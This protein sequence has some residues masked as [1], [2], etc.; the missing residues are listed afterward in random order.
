[1]A[2]RPFHRRLRKPSDQVLALLLRGADVAEQGDEQQHQHA[3]G[4]RGPDEDV[5]GKQGDV[6]ERASGSGSAGLRPLSLPS[7]LS[8][9]VCWKLRTRSSSREKSE[10]SLLRRLRA[11]QTMALAP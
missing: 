3:H 5:E 1:P 11:V 2:Q 7:S 10:R 9:A 6:H 8:K 4:E